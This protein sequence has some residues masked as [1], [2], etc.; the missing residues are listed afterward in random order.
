MYIYNKFQV[1]AVR[2][3]ALG[4]PVDN[5]RQF[6][7][8]FFLAV[9]LAL[10]TMVRT[11]F[12]QATALNTSVAL[13]ATMFCIVYVAVLFGT[14]LPQAMHRFGIDPAHSS[15]AI[16]VSMDIIGIT[17]TCVLSTIIFK[18]FES[19]VFVVGSDGSWIF[20]FDASVLD[21]N[22]MFSDTTAPLS[23]STSE[24]PDGSAILYN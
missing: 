3:I 21:W 15:A 20:N 12:I 7:H 5:K 1:L 2:A 9:V 23:G 22:S 14:L 17:I 11:T 6:I 16:Q 19:H 24:G 8:G 10:A 4:N 13:A 18:L